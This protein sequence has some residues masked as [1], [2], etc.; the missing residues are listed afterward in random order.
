MFSLPRRFSLGIG[1][2]AAAL[3]FSA[4]ASGAGAATD[5][6]ALDGGT[7]LAVQDDGYGY[8]T[9]DDRADLDA[10]LAAEVDL[11]QSQLEQAIASVEHSFDMMHEVLVSR[12]HMLYIYGGDCRVLNDNCERLEWAQASHELLTAAI[13]EAETRFGNILATGV[14]G[15]IQTQELLELQE[16]MK[17]VYEP[18][19]PYE[20]LNNFPQ[21]W[22]RD[23]PNGDPRNLISGVTQGI[24]PQSIVTGNF[25]DPGRFSFFAETHQIQCTGPYSIRTSG[26]RLIPT[27]THV[28]GHCGFNIDFPSGFAYDYDEVYGVRPWSPWGRN[29]FVGG[30]PS[31]GFFSR[32]QIVQHRGTMPGIWG[33]NLN[34]ADESFIVPSAG[35]IAIF[36]INASGTSCHQLMPHTNDAF[37]STGFGFE[38]DIEGF[39]VFR[40]QD[41]CTDESQRILLPHGGTNVSW[42]RVGAPQ[43]RGMDTVARNLRYEFIAENVLANIR[44]CDELGMTVRRGGCWDYSASDTS[45]SEDGDWFT[46]LAEYNRD[47]VCEF[48]NVHYRT[49]HQTNHTVVGLTLAEIGYSLSPAFTINL[50]HSTVMCRN[51]A[52]EVYVIPAHEDF[53]PVYDFHSKLVQI[54]LL[55]AP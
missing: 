53:A 51:S 32:E 27:G 40:H 4:C 39:I 33:N 46:A 18:D 29:V 42:T 21:H 24:G 36:G 2:V 41:W 38:R 11:V 5:S 44:S 20:N 8:S 48:S 47:W 35:N 50:A 52:G 10:E 19:G 28:D 6:P 17:T 30:I 34:L 23:L 14:E 37:S 26:D 22:L 12:Y 16:W 54:G 7:V 3:L 31:I 45:I 49:G 13:P 1:A 15:E 25:P 9:S 43:W 55:P